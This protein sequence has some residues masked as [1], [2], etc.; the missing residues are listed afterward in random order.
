MGNNATLTKVC[1]KFGIE[2]IDGLAKNTDEIGFD[3]EKRKLYRVQGWKEILDS[4]LLDS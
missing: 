4:K 2:I 3:T 1:N